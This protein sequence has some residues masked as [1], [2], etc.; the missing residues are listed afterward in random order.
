MEVGFSVW[1]LLRDLDPM[2]VYPHACFHRLNGNIRPPSK[3][4]AAGRM[5]RL[6]LLRARLVLPPGGDRW[7]HDVLD[8][9]VAALVAAQGRRQAEQV[10][11]ECPDYDGSELWV[12]V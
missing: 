9:A 10:P 1:S 11:H 12:P 3:R 5:V 2:E 6:G 8:A 7:S 4:T